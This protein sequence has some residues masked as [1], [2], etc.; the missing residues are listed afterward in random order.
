MTEKQSD[1]DLV[2][3]SL[4]R[5]SQ[6][7]IR[8]IIQRIFSK[9]LPTYQPPFEIPLQ[10]TFRKRS[11]SFVSRGVSD[12]VPFLQ[13]QGQVLPETKFCC[14]I[15]M[16]ETAYRLLIDILELDEATQYIPLLTK[17]TEENTTCYFVNCDPLSSRYSQ[18]LRIGPSPQYLDTSQFIYLL[19]KKDI[20][21]DIP[22]YCEFCGVLFPK[23][24][25]VDNIDACRLCI[26]NLLFGCSEQARDVCK[27]IVKYLG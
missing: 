11:S 8:P 1:I 9:S 24:D 12:D 23:C 19:E 13:Q 27:M 2:Y 18:L 22:V 15:D 4:R 10:S 21:G 25:I 14:G 5:K 16:F 7:D 3:Q 6:V 26:E 20:E 17:Q